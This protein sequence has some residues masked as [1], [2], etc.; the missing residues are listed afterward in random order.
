MRGIAAMLTVREGTSRH[1]NIHV[2]TLY[3]LFSWH[4][5]A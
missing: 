1:N 2:L 3:V 4:L 5:W